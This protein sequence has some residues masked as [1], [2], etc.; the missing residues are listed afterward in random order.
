[1]T[2]ITHVSDPRKLNGKKF[3][4]HFNRQIE[5]VQRVQRVSETTKCNTVTPVTLFSFL[6]CIDS[7]TFYHLAFEDPRHGLC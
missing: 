1:M 3:Y 5:R 7:I 4:G 6:L 2:N